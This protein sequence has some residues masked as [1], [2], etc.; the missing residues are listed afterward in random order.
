[1]EIV[2]LNQAAGARRGEREWHP[3][4]YRELEVYTFLD[5]LCM[6]RS[7]LYESGEPR[8]GSESKQ[9]GEGQSYAATCTR[10]GINF[11]GNRAAKELRGGVQRKGRRMNG[12]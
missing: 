3:W 10:S 5:V 12:G 9:L 2:P 1:M 11:G 7:M 4:G 8:D 6:L